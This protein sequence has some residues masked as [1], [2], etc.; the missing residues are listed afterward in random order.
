LANLAREA[1]SNSLRHAKPHRVTI[2][3]RSEPE[4]VCL[5]ISDD[6]EGF[7]PKAPPRHGVGLASMARRTAEMGGSLEIQS[8]AGKGTRVVGRIPTSLPAE[9]D[10]E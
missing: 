4:A 7:D 2:A 5:E 10:P 9:G 6:G 8:A 3:L 1:L